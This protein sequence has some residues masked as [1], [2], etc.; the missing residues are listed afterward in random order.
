MTD[1]RMVPIRSSIAIVCRGEVV[2]TIQK[3]IRKNWLFKRWKCISG[4]FAISAQVTYRKE[5]K[6]RKP[7]INQVQQV[8]VT[9]QSM[10]VSTGDLLR[11]L[12]VAWFCSGEDIFFENHSNLSQL[13]CR[14]LSADRCLHHQ[15][16]NSGWR[17]FSYWS[18]S[19]D[20]CGA[21]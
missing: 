2:R 14:F 17:R 1:D 9:R 3:K 5:K 13:L 10:A 6:K 7:K 11:L 15:R 16:Q 12:L 21:A 18:L 8:R 20:G 19:V 4:F